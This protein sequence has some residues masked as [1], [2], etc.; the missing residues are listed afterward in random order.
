[1]ICSVHPGVFTSMR[2]D[3]FG[4]VFAFNSVYADFMRTVLSLDLRDAVHCSTRI[5]DRMI[6]QRSEGES[7]LAVDSEQIRESLPIGIDRFVVF[8]SKSQ[9]LLSSGV[10]TVHV[11]QPRL[12]DPEDKR[13]FFLIYFNGDFSVSAVKCAVRHRKLLVIKALGHAL[14]S[15]LTEYNQMPANDSR[16]V[17]LFQISLFSLFPQGHSLR[18]KISDSIFEK[19]FLSGMEAAFGNKSPLVEVAPYF[20]CSLCSGSN[21]A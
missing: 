4:L 3:G 5:S 18:L 12:T 11:F 9:D 16:L 1:M 7:S 17:S 10:G 19:T 13:R 8:P 14:M 6:L 2:P 21:P 15:A 20:T